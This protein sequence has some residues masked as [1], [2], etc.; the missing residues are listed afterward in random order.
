MDESEIVKHGLKMGYSGKITPYIKGRI[1]TDMKSKDETKEISVEIKTEHIKK[2]PKQQT[3][4]SKIKRG[5]K[6]TSVYLLDCSERYR[7]YQEPESNTSVK[8]KSVK[9]AHKK[10]VKKAVKKSIKKSVSGVSKKS[11]KMKKQTAASAR[12]TQQDTEQEIMEW[13]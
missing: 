9:K 8:T 2:S 1:L 3:V 11:R 4:G 5:I 6:R 13:M 10:P 7:E 12:K